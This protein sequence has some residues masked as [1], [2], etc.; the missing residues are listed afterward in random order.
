M[1]EIDFTTCRVEDAKLLKND[2]RMNKS[3]ASI[4]NTE[5]GGTRTIK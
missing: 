2:M 4:Y 1:I 3:I 5:L